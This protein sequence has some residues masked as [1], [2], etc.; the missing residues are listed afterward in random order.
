MI[1]LDI[2]TLSLVAVLVTLLM[3]C[4]MLLL[5]RLNP[6]ERSARSWAIGNAAIAIGF[7][8]IG[9]RGILPLFISVP[10]A[11]TSIVLGYGLLL[12]GVWEFLGQSK[13]W[14]IVVSATAFVFFSFLYFTYLSPDI[15]SRIVIVSLVIAALSGVSAQCLLKDRT[16]RMRKIQALTAAVFGLHALY[17]S[18]R[19]IL[20]LAGVHIQ[21]LFASNWVQ[22]LAFL[23]VI[24]SAICLTFA[25]T[26]MINRRLQFHLNHLASYDLLTEVFNRRA[27]EQAAVREMSRCARHKTMLS[28]LLLDIDHFK[29]INDRYGH[30]VGD[31]VLKS[32]ATAIVGALRKEDV[33][34]RIGGEEFCM[35]L[36]ESDQESAIDISERVR[37][38]VCTNTI[39]HEG[40]T[41]SITVSIGVATIQPDDTSWISLFQIADQA[42]YRAKAGGRNLI[43]I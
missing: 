29:R 38:A 34:G 1:E 12:V 10:V 3:A 20:T 19:S 26:S 31:Q 27:F 4:A 13:R 5:W 18:L 24:V 2:R 33:L 37:M 22:G 43:A 28:V 35:L 40:Q 16:P 42:L 9:F 39:T 11:N 6:E 25:F 8:C 17:L 23:D 36:P 41:I 30:S 32:T 14:W 21:D 15:P 7:L